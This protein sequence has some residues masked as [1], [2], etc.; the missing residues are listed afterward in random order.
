MTQGLVDKLDLQV[1]LGLLI[2]LFLYILA[3]FFFSRLGRKNTI[4]RAVLGFSKWLFLLVGL[5]FCDLFL[6][7]S[8]DVHIPQHL[9][10]L[11]KI[12]VVWMLIKSF[13]DGFY[14]EVYLKKIRKKTVNY[15][16]LDFL[17]LLF[18][19]ALVI[20]VIKNVFRVNPGSILTSS[21]ILTAIIGLSI[22]D[23][24]GSLISGLLIQ[25]EKPFKVGDWIAVGE[26]EGKVVDISWRYTKIETVT[27]DYL[28]IPNN[29]ISR[30]TLV[31]YSQPISKVMRV[32]DIGAG[33]DVPPI[34]VKQALREVIS[35]VALV[36]RYPRPV[37]RL[38]RYEDYRIIYRIIFYVRNF[39]DSWQAWDEL[40]TS[41]WYQ[42]QKAGIEISLPRQDIYLKKEQKREDSEGV[43]RILQNLP[44]FSGLSRQD[45]DLLLRSAVIRNYP[46]E[47]CIIRQGDDDTNLFVILS[48]RVKVMRGQKE[49]AVL[50]T[51]DFFGEMALLAGAS[52]SA[53]IYSLEEAT[54]L[55]IDREAFRI[56]LE[57]N[58][59]VYENINKLFVERSKQAQSRESGKKMT[60]AESLLA[61]FKSIF[62]QP[63][64]L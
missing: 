60:S 29:S 16:V 48:G 37:A 50:E 40:Y 46:P 49:L 64:G 20:L 28:L 25:L 52:R 32:L 23:T 30:D 18:F 12:L 13:L 11:L 4:S 6:F 19:C 59:G 57:M 5:Y 51:G 54:C 45:L 39:E 35:K 62:C 42:F 14:A 3:S 61:K 31:N 17:K 10:F 24:I 47:V 9:L 53:D 36:E 63:G 41:I 33:Y 8:L 56:L 1:W 22:Q 2:F 27:L 7:P 26:R 44:L 58:S 34:K 43:T 55:M 15:I 38:N 21:A